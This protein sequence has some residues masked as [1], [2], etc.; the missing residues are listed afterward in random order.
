LPVQTLVL[1][2][3]GRFTKVCSALQQARSGHT[4]TR[5]ADGRVLVAGGRDVTGGVL[6][7][8]E[9]LE[10]ALVVPSGTLEI[11]SQGQSFSLPRSRQAALLV[12]QTGQVYFS[13][14]ETGP[15]A[16]PTPLST[17]LF[18]DPTVD[19]AFGAL[20]PATPPRLG[21][22]RHVALQL[23]DAAL[24]VGGMT[25]P[26]NGS[27]VVASDV[28][29][30]LELST[31]TMTILAPL[32]EAREDASI[33]LLGR[34]VLVVGG[35]L[36]G[37]SRAAIDVL[38]AGDATHATRG[39]LL[40]PRAGAALAV[41]GTRAFVAGGVDSTGT[42]TGTTEWVT[43]SSSV[44]GP[45]LVPRQHA[46]AVTLGSRVLIVGGEDANGPSAAAELIETDGSVTTLPF[47]GAPRVEHACVALEDGGALIVGG[48]GSSGALDDLWQF[49][50]P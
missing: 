24:L 48:R 12:E 39:S 18:T 23:D 29:E 1:Y 26:A 33:A 31:A 13:G 22:T 34:D 21:R 30:R 32:P 16:T 17:H 7:S 10:G 8:M 14:G 45:N 40:I 6:A 49:T 44:A 28:V 9:R 19:F 4:A 27:A 2:P 20:G 11:R 47:G 41:V 15:V 50:A 36:G 35:R 3:V 5:L 25:R 42:L 37:V 46:C 43:A 38:P